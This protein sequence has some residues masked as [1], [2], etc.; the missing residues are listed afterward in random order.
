[1]PN[2]SDIHEFRALCLYALGRYDDAAATLYAVLSVGPGWDWTTLIGLY[3]DV[4]VYTAQL[5]I[6]EDY[7]AAHADSA[8]A[9]FVLGYHYL[10]EGHTETAV[11]VLKRVVA[12]KPSDTL[13]MK[14]LRQ[15]DPT[16]DKPSAPATATAATNPTET[17]PPAGA[18]I[19]GTWTAQPVAGTAIALTMQPGGEF[20][21]Q[22][23][24]NGRTQQFNGSSTYGDGILT[25]AQEKGP[26]LVGRV[27]WKDPS[28]MI[29]RVA[30][31]GS[32]DPGLSFA[33]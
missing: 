23:T 22:V 8:P 29:F 27:S 14:L 12:L 4:S 3:S 2:D 28:H 25:L 1:M 7:C 16:L 32:D 21:W 5:R 26:A 10:T 30:G 18:T 20:A 17:T 6:L 24:Q 15:L 9:Y 13:S 31:D 11:H 19:A 33:K